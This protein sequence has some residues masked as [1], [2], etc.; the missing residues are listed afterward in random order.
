MARPAGRPR[1]DRS[2]E[3]HSPAAA[4]PSNMPTGYISA[5]ELY[6]LTEIRRRLKMSN[7]AWWALRDKGCP[8]IPA[9]KQLLVYGA[10]VIE[11]LKGFTKAKRRRRICL[12]RFVNPEPKLLK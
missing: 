6:T 8:H 2:Q 1:K 7:E 5:N 3:M 4:K 10:D 9:G 12:D 11:W